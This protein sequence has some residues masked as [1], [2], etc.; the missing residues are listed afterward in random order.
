MRVRR[1]SALGAAVV[2]CSMFGSAAVAQEPDTVIDV[3]VEP[4]YDTGE[5]G[6]SV[7]VGSAAVAAEL[8]GRS[9]NVV[10]TA[11]NQSSVHPGNTLVVSSGESSVSVAGIEDAAGA[12]STE[13]GTIT[14]GD[15]ISLAV[16][17]GE[18]G[19]TS[20][21]SSLKVTCEALPEATPTPPTPAEPTYTG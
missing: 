5:V 2:L 11:T 13:A 15:T 14:L 12:V 20:V 6:A 18:D 19:A 21:G 3:P 1:L 16:V 9:C 17:L 10:V 4:V 8:V 7:A